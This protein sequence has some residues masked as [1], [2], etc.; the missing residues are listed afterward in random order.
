MFMLIL[1]ALHTLRNV[2]KIGSKH[3]A[4]I[5]KTNQMQKRVIN[6]HKLFALRKINECNSFR[7]YANVP[8]E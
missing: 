7:Y 5:R 8:L 4:T 3:T 2:I 6:K 1:L